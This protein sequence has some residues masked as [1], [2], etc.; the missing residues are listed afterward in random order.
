MWQLPAPTANQVAALLTHGQTLHEVAHLVR[1][2]QTPDLGPEA[3]TRLAARVVD[4]YQQGNSI[5]QV[6]KTVERSY[7]LVRTLLLESRCPLREPRGGS[8][9]AACRQQ[10]AT[11]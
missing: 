5:R 10:A 11:R 1:P 8:R 6:S 3:R 4:L 7:T 9:R 2:S